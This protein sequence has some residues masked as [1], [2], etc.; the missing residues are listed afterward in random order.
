MFGFAK[1][2][3]KHTERVELLLRIGA[4]LRASRAMGLS[5]W[6]SVHSTYIVRH[7]HYHGVP[8]V[9]CTVCTV[10]YPSTPMQRGGDVHKT[11]KCK[12]EAGQ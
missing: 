3:E 5:I 12:N 10:H 11:A 7:F 8:R 6:H 9:Q 1:H 2:Y 4:A